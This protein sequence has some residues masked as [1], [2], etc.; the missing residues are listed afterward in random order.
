MAKKQNP[1]KT[2]RDLLAI[3]VGTQQ[4]LG[5]GKT[6]LYRGQ[7]YD[8]TSFTALVD[9]LLAPY[10]RVHDMRTLAE[11]SVEDRRVNEPQAEEFV[12]LFKVAASAAYGENS[13]EFSQLGFK[14]RKEA[15]A[16]TP[17]Q[18]QLKLERMRATRAAR[19][20]MGRRQRAQVKGVVNPGQPNG[21]TGPAAPGTGTNPVTK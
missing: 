10:T 19:K 3:R 1:T 11:K 20:T 16:L 8:Q 14:P 18:K 2:E 6:I 7:T 4:V 17:E 9:N 13:L 12:R 21:S 15:A 5:G